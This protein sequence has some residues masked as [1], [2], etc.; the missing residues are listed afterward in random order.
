M[1]E[2]E[3]FYFET[4]NRTIITSVSLIR[5]F[6]GA[7]EPTRFSLSLTRFDFHKNIFGEMLKNNQ[8]LGPG[9]YSEY[10]A[11]SF[12]NEA[13]NFNDKINQRNINRFDSNFI[14]I[15]LNMSGVV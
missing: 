1:F 14:I 9:L 5:E 15:S 8:F 3:I 2:N 13:I 10:Y 12:N 7:L 11:A 4:T 6:I